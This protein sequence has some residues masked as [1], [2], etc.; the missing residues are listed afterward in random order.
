MSKISFMWRVSKSTLSRYSNCTEKKFNIQLCN[1]LEIKKMYQKAFEYQALYSMIQ[2]WLQANAHSN[3]STTHY[4]NG[5]FGNVL[6]ISVSLH[7]LGTK[8][9][10]TTSAF[11][12]FPT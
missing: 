1:E 9:L 12:S 2:F 8:T 10:C 3:I 6:V 7:L 4:G 5:V 11:D